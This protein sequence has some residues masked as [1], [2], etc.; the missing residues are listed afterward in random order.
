MKNIN[1]IKIIKV[2]QSSLT[3]QLT[4]EAFNDDHDDNDDHDMIII[5]KAIRVHLLGS[6]LQRRS[7]GTDLSEAEREKGVQI[8]LE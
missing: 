6:P 8:N 3:E 5:M 2:H 1:I 4:P 7:P